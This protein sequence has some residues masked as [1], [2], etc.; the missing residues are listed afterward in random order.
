MLTAQPITRAEAVTFARQHGFTPLPAG[1]RW[2]AVDGLQ[3][4]V[5]VGARFLVAGEN[6][7]TG[8]I[9]LPNAGERIED[10]VME[11]QR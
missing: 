1:Y 4:A 11:A 7:L 3:T 9:G 5:N 2:Y 6:G 8:I 10:A